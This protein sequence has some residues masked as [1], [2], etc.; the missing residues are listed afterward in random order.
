MAINHELIVTIEENSVLAGAGSGVSE[1]L[2][3]QGLVVD[4][5][6]LGIPDRFISQ[7]KPD[8]M[9]AEC[10]LNVEGILESIRGRMSK[11]ENKSSLS[12]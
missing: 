10:G 5:L 8:N 7:D 6:N 3:G 4:I 12:L 11:V 1:F 9:L 2:H